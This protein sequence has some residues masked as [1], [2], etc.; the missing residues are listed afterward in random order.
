MARTSQLWEK[1]KGDRRI[2][3]NADETEF[4]ALQRGISNLDAGIRDDIISGEM[5]DFVAPFEVDRWAEDD[6]RL[7]ESHIPLAEEILRRKKL[8]GDLYPFEEENNWLTYRPRKNSSLIYEFCLAVS[9][10]QSLTKGKAAYLPRTFE[11]LALVATKKYIGKGAWGIRTGWPWDKSHQATSFR[12]IVNIINHRT[13]E[14]LWQPPHDF[15]DNPSPQYVKDLGMD[16]VVAKSFADQRR[17]Q[18]FLVGQCACGNDWES[19]LYDLNASA[20]SN[21]FRAPVSVVPFVR[22]FATPRHIAND[23]HFYE[24][25]TKAGLTLDRVRIVQIME[26]ESVKKIRHRVKDLIGVVITGF[27]ADEPIS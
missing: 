16:F 11:R 24:V 12:D 2:A 22:V 10:A 14:W 4:A 13:N 5:E 17:G 15:P 23:A 3:E 1:R 19:K 27:Q 8:L 6:L 21:W 25:G 7:D 26:T 20:I 18:I 9:C